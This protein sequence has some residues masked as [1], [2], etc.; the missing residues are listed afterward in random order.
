M[1]STPTTVSVTSARRRG[2]DH[3]LRVGCACASRN[4][5]ACC[6]TFAR[7]RRS[8]SGDGPRGAKPIA[9]TDVSRMGRSSSACCGYRERTVSIS[10]PVSIS[11]KHS[12]KTS[13][14]SFIVHLP[15]LALQGGQRT[16]LES[17][18]SVDILVQNCSR[19]L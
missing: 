4:R 19:F 15:D 17:F 9:C 3:S 10:V 12:S 18:Y 11:C 14:S 7:P 6:S 1:N 8:T 16:E 2:T 13:Y 5:A